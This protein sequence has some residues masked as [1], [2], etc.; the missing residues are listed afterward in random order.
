MTDHHSSSRARD[1]LFSH[2]REAPPMHQD[3][4]IGRKSH[5]ACGNPKTH[6]CDRDTC[7][8]GGRR[9][10]ITFG[11]YHARSIER[12]RS[13]GTDRFFPSRRERRRH[14]LGAQ[15][16]FELDPLHLRMWIACRELRRHFREV[17]KLVN[18]SRCRH[19]IRADHLHPMRDQL[20]ACHTVF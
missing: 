5:R 12:R 19:H 17:I 18:H 6:G 8:F 15:P 20:P 11:L 9:R 2:V 10:S 1:G 4:D 14:A 3:E 13:S 7:G 16:C